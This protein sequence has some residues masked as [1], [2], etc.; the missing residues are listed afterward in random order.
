MSTE[1]IVRIENLTKTFDFAKALDNV[2]VEIL[3]GRIVGLLGANG[4][5]KSTLLRHMIGL[6]LQDEGE[7]RTFG[8]PAGTLTPADIAR[9]GYVHQEGE[10]LD[11]MTVD[12]IIRYAA[13]YYPGWNMELEKRYRRE[14]ELRSEA[15]VGALSP[16]Q[17]QKLAILLAIGFEPE[18]LILD[19]PAAALDPIARRN[20]LDLLLDIIQDPTRTIIISSHILSDVEKVIDHVVI[21]DR[22][23]IL[24]DVSL[25]DLREEFMKVSLTALNGELPEDLPFS[26]VLSATRGGGQAVLTMKAVPRDV[27]ES[28]ASGL[29]CEI[30]VQTLTLEELYC[31][32]MQE[33]RKG[34]AA[35]PETGNAAG[36]GD[37]EAGA[38]RE[39]VR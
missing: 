30:G 19:E 22:G 10:L 26:G 14:F 11:W 25:D 3:P 9:I 16:G 8:R 4:G 38:G 7:C 20:F 32:V 35:A 24:R 33:K 2:S 12:Q 36:G 18:L 31:L 39:A 29:N 34:A 17:R 13:A 23:R 28:R 15:R 1:P 27:L 21:V 37:A 6:Y 5:G